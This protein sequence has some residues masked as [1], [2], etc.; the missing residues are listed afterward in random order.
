[1]GR[2]NPTRT[3]EGRLVHIASTPDIAAIADELRERVDLS[4]ARQIIG[5]VGAPGT[6]K[7]TLADLVAAE[8][9]RELC[10]VVPMDGFHLAQSIIAGTP[11]A[12]RRGAIDTFDVGG[13]LS[14]LQRLQL[15][16]EPVVYAPY[17]RRGLEEPIGSGIAIS[18]QIPVIIT[19]GNYLLADQEPWNHI[20][21]Y[22]TETWFVE[23][24]RDVRLQRLI[25]RHVAFGKKPEA[26]AAWA[27]GPDE[28]N[29]EYVESTR[30][31]ADRIVDWI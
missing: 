1:V 30:H 14:L 20:R 28:A 27:L 15:R 29:A 18:S 16:N 6:G 25:D 26:A 22:L 31:H 10:L 21:D 17:F 24:P 12:G 7:S 8:L 5:I 19:E 13:Y 3:H 4:K 9:G 11:L 23:T 2:T